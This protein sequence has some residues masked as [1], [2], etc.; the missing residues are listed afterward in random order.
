MVNDYILLKWG[1]LKGWSLANSPDAMEIVR[2]YNEHGV[3]MSVMLQT[4]S[5][6]QKDLLLKLIDI[7][8]GDIF[9][10]WDGKKY[11]KE[12]AKEYIINYGLED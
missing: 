5:E 8:D 9:N 7:F 2:Q 4:D 10:D 12:Q 1:T 6:T 3:S 11:T